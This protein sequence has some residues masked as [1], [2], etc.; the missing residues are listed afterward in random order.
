[1]DLNSKKM[2]D[3]DI[4]KTLWTVLWTMISITIIFFLWNES[5]R[6]VFELK[7]ITLIQ[8]ACFY[9]MAKVVT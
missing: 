5:L 3:K 4:L 7:E 9:L 6:F 8:S 2:I 1:M